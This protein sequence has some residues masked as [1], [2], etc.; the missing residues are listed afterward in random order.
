MLI[1]S[2]S[3]QIGWEVLQFMKRCLLMSLFL[4]AQL[5]AFF[6]CSGKSLETK[7]T[8][9]LTPVADLAWSDS[10]DDDDSIEDVSIFT[11]TGVLSSEF[12]D[13]Y[14]QPL[15]L[16]RRITPQRVLFTAL[17]GSRLADKST[18]PPLV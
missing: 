17:A 3:E 14:H 16:V 13:S 12:L 7:N 8:T 15:V 1:E 6:L 2:P 4:L 10:L 18:G 5:S 9:P 11:T